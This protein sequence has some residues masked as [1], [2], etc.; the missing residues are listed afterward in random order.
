[1]INVMG[2]ITATCQRCQI[3]CWSLLGY[4]R[5]LLQVVGH[6]L[7]RKFTVH[8]IP[9]VRIVPSG[10]FRVRQGERDRV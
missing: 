1:M 9:R 5:L 2:G 8:P 10:M 4:S 6:H 7:M 3:G